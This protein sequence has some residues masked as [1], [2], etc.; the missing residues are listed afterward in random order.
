MVA[1][2]R[3]NACGACTRAHEAWALRTGVSANE[4]E[5]IGAGELAALSDKEQAA[6]VYATALWESRFGAIPNDA[7]ALVDAHLD[8]ERQQD[9]EVIARLMTFANLSAN[10]LRALAGSV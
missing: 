8:S 10:S 4:L 5:Q 7:R 1:V 6:I 9:I 2:S 3:A